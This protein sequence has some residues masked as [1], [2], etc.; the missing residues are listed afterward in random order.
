MRASSWSAREGLEHVVV[1]AGVEGRD[2]LVVVV[3]GGGDDDRHR[4]DGTQ[5]PQQLAAV[6][7]RQPEVEDDEVRA[8]LDG[9]AAGPPGRC[10]RS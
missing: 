3:P 6:E 1:G 5:H 9:A 2:D 8:V 7:V 10:P 4:G